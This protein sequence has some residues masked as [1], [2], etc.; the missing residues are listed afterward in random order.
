MSMIKGNKQLK[1]PIWLDRENRGKRVSYVMTTLN[2]LSFLRESMPR[3]QSEVAED[4]ELLV[5][6]GASTDG[7]HEYLTTIAEGGGIDWYLSKTDHCEAHA[8]NKAILAARGTYI[9]V[10][11][12]DDVFDFGVLRQLHDYLDENTEVSVAYPSGADTSWDVEPFVRAGAN[13]DVK[14]MRRHIQDV[15]RPHLFSGLGL[16]FRR[17]ALPEIGLF[18]LNF[19][20][21]DTALACRLTSSPVRLAACTLFGYVRILNEQSV[22]TTMGKRNFEEK[23][24]LTS[25]YGGNGYQSGRA[26]LAELGKRIQERFLPGNHGEDLETKQVKSAS[27]APLSP[28]ERMRFAEQWLQQANTTQKAEFIRRG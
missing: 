28:G 6:D 13:N 9:T 25:F 17:A 15:S 22:T 18:D 14:R 8:L 24:R 10:L 4:E 20:R 26:L 27:S 11:T 2:K 23:K 5:V 1:S 12:D 19:R 7:S 3:F 21:V 16:T